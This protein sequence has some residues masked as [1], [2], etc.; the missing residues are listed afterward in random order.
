MASDYRSIEAVRAASPFC[1]P[2]AFA[3]LEAVIVNLR[4]EWESRN[5][6]WR[7]LRQL[8][9]LTAMDHARLGPAGRAKLAELRAKFPQVTHDP[10]QAM[11]VSSVGSPISANAQGKMTDD[12]W[13][14]A[15]A[16][17]T[18]V[19]HRRDRNFE[20]SGGEY[21]LAQSLESRTKADPKRFVALSVRI[22]ANLSAVYFDA[23]IRGVAATAPP[24]GSDADTVSISEVIP[25]VE[26]AHAVPGCPCGRSIVHLV[27]NW[28][29]VDWP[30]TVIEIVAWYATNDPDPAEEVWCK[31]APGGQFY[32]G[33]APDMYG[34]NSTR[35]AAANAIARLL[36][37]KREPKD[38]LVVAVDRLAHD[39]SIAV[40]SQAIYALLA[41]LNARSDLAI[42]WFVEC[43]SLDP[44]LLG[45]RF[46]EH[47][48]YYAGHR[49][50]A[51]IRPV[52]QTMLASVDAK[53]V[54]LGGRMCC[55]LAL[56]VD[57][58]K[59]DADQ[60]RAGSGAM[61]KS[62]AR[63]YATNVAHK[64]V[65]TMCRQ[66]L[67]P[68][69]ADAED[70]V[71]AE[72]A[73]AFRNIS[74]LDAA[75]QGELLAAFLDAKPSSTAL[76][77][78]IRA[79]EDSPVRLPDLVCRLVEAGLE[80]FRAEAGDI[81]KAG[82]MVASDLSKIVIR[83]YTQSDDVKI[84]DRCLDAIDRMEHAGFF[85]LAEELGKVDR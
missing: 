67:L 77:P 47:F 69:F 82:A 79:L 24:D 28:G 27:G 85:G 78:V 4:D 43:V 39:I 63:I 1:S 26:R 58:A 61:R 66:L 5:P 25:L 57:V 65:G 3:A 29:K 7:G 31:R 38:V 15:M 59:P 11:K 14:S 22:P 81:R 17:Y 36:F 32:Y 12:Q 21:E 8:Q 41:L 16:K 76:E 68:F 72:A 53:T 84:K 42:P 51:A 10:P 2:E 20:A 9:L 74:E 30:P 49:D 23:I 19:E 64:E 34:L 48:I 70:S 50:Y 44:I 83:L 60:A 45:T 71:R 62:A 13:L 18:G 33:G 52:I 6:Q 37:D 80:T 54:E 55:L 56:D 46:V 40:R 35:G 73:A 75:E